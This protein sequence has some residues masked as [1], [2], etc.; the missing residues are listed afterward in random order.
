MSNEQK[1]IQIIDLLFKINDTVFLKFFDK[2]SDKML[3]KKISVM[4]DLVNGKPP[5]EIPGYYEVLELYPGDKQ[6]WD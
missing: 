1:Q 3:D 2:D 6:I 4:T 5:G